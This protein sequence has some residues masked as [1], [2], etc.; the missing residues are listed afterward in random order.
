[1][2]IL[3][4]FKTG[5]TVVLTIDPND[6]VLAVKQRMLDK[7]GIPVEDQKYV[8]EGKLLDDSIKVLDCGVVVESVVHCILAPP[9]TIKL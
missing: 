2:Q 4:V 7:E 8:F 9:K 3:V 1:M 6:T 5:K